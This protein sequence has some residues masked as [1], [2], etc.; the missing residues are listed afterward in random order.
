MR[1]VQVTPVENGILRI[2]TADG[3]EGLF[4]VKPY[5]RDEPFEPL[6]EARE[7][8]AV[9]N[10][11]YYVEWPCGADLSADTMEAHMVWMAGVE[12]SRAG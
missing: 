3:R 7:F 4:D 5:F 10:G 12:G 6:S 8:Q 2:V 9:I 11:G 1:I